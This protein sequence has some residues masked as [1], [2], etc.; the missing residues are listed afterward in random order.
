MLKELQKEAELMASLRHPNI[1]L[2]MGMCPEPPCVI[3]EFCA[4]GSLFDVLARVG[5][6]ARCRA[7]LS[8]GAAECCC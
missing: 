6:A 4:L 2:F 5:G 1:V 3:T 8:S 7:V